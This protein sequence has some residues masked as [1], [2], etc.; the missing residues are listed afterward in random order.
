LDAIIFIYSIAVLGIW[1]KKKKIKFFDKLKQ[2]HV[3]YPNLVQSYLFIHIIFL[4]TLYSLT[5]FTDTEEQI[6]Y[7]IFYFA[8][9]FLYFSCLINTHSFSQNKPESYSPYFLNAFAL[10]VAIAYVALGY[11]DFLGENHDIYSM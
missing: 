1:S 3:N 5:T 4:S 10:I 9:L 2:L 11:V 7:F 8:P 6:T